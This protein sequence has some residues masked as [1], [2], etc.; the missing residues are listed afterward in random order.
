MCTRQPCAP[1]V[2]L[3]E[4]NLSQQELAE[5]YLGAI[6][7][8][9]IADTIER[10]E[11]I[12]LSEERICA[13]IMDGNV[14]TRA[15]AHTVHTTEFTKTIL[16]RKKPHTAVFASSCDPRVNNSL[17]ALGCH[18]TDKF[19]VYKTVKAHVLACQYC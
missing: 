6:C 1:I 14:P 11:S 15:G 13:I 8:L 16:A 4:D 12:F 10:A 2:L 5:S 18:P 9:I 3:V 7:T 19:S 17:I